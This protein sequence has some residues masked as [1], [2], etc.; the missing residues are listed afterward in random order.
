MRSLWQTHNRV[1][2]FFLVAILLASAI[3]FVIAIS[4][5]YGNPT[6]GENNN[7]T[8]QGNTRSS[9]NVLP[10]QIT[11][12]KCYSGA[13]YVST[14]TDKSTYE[15]GQN[16]NITVAMYGNLWNSKFNLTVNVLEPNSTTY[17]S[18]S[19]PSILFLG[20]ICPQ[21]PDGS[22]DHSSHFSEN[23]TLPSYSPKGN[24]KVSSIVTVAGVIQPGQKQVTEAKCSFSVDA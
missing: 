2:V 24:W 1:A 19:D 15:P 9:E 22:A 17:V 5:F 18:F 21:Q 6:G 12:T 7:R 20:P 10:G 23:F 4:H 3:F 11:Q 8:T 14:T 16:V 13:I